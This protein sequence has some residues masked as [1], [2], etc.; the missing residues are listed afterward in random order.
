MIIIKLL[1]LLAVVYKCNAESNADVLNAKVERNIDLTTHLAKVNTIITV[2]NKGS[3]SLTSYTFVIE[4]T[5]ASNVVYIGAQLSNVK[6]DENDNK[7]TLQ[8]TQTQQNA[9]YF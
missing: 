2:E 3:N 9:K 1:L 7:N 8:V 6:N 4:P 5:H